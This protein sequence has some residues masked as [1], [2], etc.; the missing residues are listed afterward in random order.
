MDIPVDADV[1][2]VDGLCGRSAG[3]IIGQRNQVTHIIIKPSYGLERLAPVDKVAETSPAVIHLRCTVDE[4]EQMDN[5]IEQEYVMIWPDAFM[6]VPAPQMIPV[7]HRLI[8]K[9]ELAIERGSNVEAADGHAGKVD[10][11]IV[12]PADEHITHLVLREGHLWG[13]KDVTI[14]VSGIDRIED[15]TIYLKLDKHTI[16]SLPSVP[17][18]RQRKQVGVQ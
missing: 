2:C 3:V 17:L 12:D 6:W 18:R 14:P 4:V 10:E 9:G 1:K 11:L 13:Q 8:P 5:F 7:P 15:D 16:E